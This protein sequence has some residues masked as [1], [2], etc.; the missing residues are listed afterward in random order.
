MD[1]LSIDL[2]NAQVTVE[3]GGRATTFPLAGAEDFDAV[4]QAWLRASWDAKYRYSFTWFGRPVI[5]VAEDLIRVQELVF[6]V[7]PDVILE[8]GVA[9]GGS[10]VFYAGLG[11]AMGKG[12]VIG[13]DIEIRPPNRRGPSPIGTG[14]IQNRR[15]RNS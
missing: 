12:R 10:L 15:P 6:E 11:K 7:K 14:T 9:H 1:R 3:D 13:V 5:Q 4:S 8:T 2:R